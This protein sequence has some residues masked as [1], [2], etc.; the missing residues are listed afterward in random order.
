MLQALYNSLHIHENR[1]AF[2]I[3]GKYYTYKQLLCLVSKVRY[4]IK[5]SVPEKIVGLVANDDLETYA[6]ILALWFEGKAYVPLHPDAPVERNLNVIRLSEM[7]TLLTSQTVDYPG[8]QIED[9]TLFD[10]VLVEDII[11]EHAKEDLAYILFTSGSTGVPKGVPIN[12]AN[13]AG[14]V[15]AFYALGYKIDAEDRCLQMFDLTFDLSVMSYLI[16]LLNGACVYTIPHSEIKYSY[17]AE[18]METQKLTVALMVPS[19]LHYLRPYYDEIECDS[20]KYSLFCGEALPLEMIEEWGKCVPAARIDNVYGPTED[21]IF[22]TAYSFRRNGPNKSWNG[23]LS[24]G[25]AM[26]GTLTMIV[27]GDGEPVAVGDTGEL[28]LAGV[29]LTPGY[30]MNEEKNAESFFLKDGIRFYRTGDL[31]SE[32]ADGDIMYHGR[33]DFQAKIQGFRV[34]LSEIEYHVKKIVGNRVN[35]V[36]VAFVNAI[37]NTEIGL[38]FESDSFDV[39][40]CLEELKQRLPAYMIPTRVHFSPHFPLNV[41]GKIDRKKLKELFG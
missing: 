17:I 2:C 6:S 13:I 24:I 27:N 32:D 8:V 1:N 23:V 5:E 26:K 33:A 41:N 36:A 7:K 38:V 35:A 30:W 3:N 34:E 20:M 15:E 19:I 9:T 31:C 18:L 25:K 16:P 12:L 11:E 14:F 28:C 21:T 4:R 39:T 40:F 22:C 29:Q 10:Q 37:G